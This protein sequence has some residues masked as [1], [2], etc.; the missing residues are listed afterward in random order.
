LVLFGVLMLSEPSTKNPS[1]TRLPQTSKETRIQQDNRLQ[2]Y[3]LISPSPAF[4]Y[5]QA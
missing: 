2:I 5:E 1:S 4:S 3:F